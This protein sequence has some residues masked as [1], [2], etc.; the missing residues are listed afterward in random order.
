MLTLKLTLTTQLPG[1][2]LPGGHRSSPWPSRGWATQPQSP[3]RTTMISGQRFEVQRVP[4]GLI[5]VR[6]PPRAR[7]KPYN[8]SSPWLPSHYTCLLLSGTNFPRVLNLWWV[9]LSGYSLLWTKGTWM[10]LVWGANV[11]CDWQGC[12]EY[13]GYVVWCSTHGTHTE[14]EPRR[15]P[16]MGVKKMRERDCA[17][18]SLSRIA[19][20]KAQSCFPCVCACWEVCVCVWLGGWV[21]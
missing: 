14:E 6:S 18:A 5:M 8:S 2:C 1:L 19:A 10:G 13:L 4:P 3:Q 17:V 7:G 20:L 16:P 11:C 21:G 15:S 9:V 12:C